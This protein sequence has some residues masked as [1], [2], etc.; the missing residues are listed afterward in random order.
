MDSRTQKQIIIAVI[1]FGLLFLIGSGFYFLFRSPASCLDGVRNQNEVGID[2]GGAC[3]PCE[4]ADLKPVEI[5]WKELFPARAD[6]YDAAA[7]I[8]NPNLRHGTSAL[9]YTFTLF[10]AAGREVGKKSGKD[11]ILPGQ[12]KYIIEPLIKVA[13]KPSAAMF[14]I[15]QAITWEKLKD[16]EEIR[17]PVQKRFYSRTSAQA[18]EIGFSKAEGTVFNNSGFDF[19]RVGVNVVLFDTLGRPIAANKTEMRTLTAGEERFFKVIWFNPFEGEV[20]KVDMEAEVNLF[21]QE[22]FIKRLGQ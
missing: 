22:T 11:F 5:V 19:D 1:F 15:S 18:G 2:C 4:E 13:G 3:G 6:V 17:L 20:K 9:S 10:D 21:L 7:K 16:F 12:S 14:A 8:R